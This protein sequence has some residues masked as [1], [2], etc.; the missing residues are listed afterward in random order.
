MIAGLDGC[1]AGAA[2]ASVAEII[3]GEGVAAAALDEA[4]GGGFVIFAE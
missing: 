4:S 1:P 3:P 2:I